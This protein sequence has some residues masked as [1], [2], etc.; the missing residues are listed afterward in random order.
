M[1]KKHASTEVLDF[2]KK[3]FITKCEK[4]SQNKRV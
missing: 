1:H 2:S 4:Q 3:L